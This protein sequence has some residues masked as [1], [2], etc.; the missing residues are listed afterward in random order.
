MTPKELINKAKSV[1]VDP[2]VVASLESQMNQ[3]GLTSKQISYLEGLID[4]NQTALNGYSP[5]DS[6][7]SYRIA[8]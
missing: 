6:D 8:G 7:Y 2:D 1:N 4:E 5:Y 3:R